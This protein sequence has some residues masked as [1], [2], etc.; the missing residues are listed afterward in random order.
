ML[1]GSGRHKI[2]SDEQF[3]LSLKHCT[4]L[5]LD[6]LI[7]I[8]GDDSNTN[9][10]LL[11]EYFAKKKAKTIVCGCPK[12]IDGDLKNEHIPVSF[13]FDTATKVFSEEIGNLCT[14]AVSSQGYYYFVRVMG[15]SASHIALECAVRTRTN[16]CLIGEEVQAKKMTLEQITT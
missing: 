11:G 5:D 6:G 7:V 8:G 2:E 16:G 3:E 1:S 15:R 12:T 10:C 9:A 4:Q 14:D 13:G